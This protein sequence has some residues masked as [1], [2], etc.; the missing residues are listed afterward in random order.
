MRKQ[1]PKKRVIAIRK[2][3]NW[4]RFFV[5]LALFTGIFLLSVDDIKTMKDV[6]LTTHMNNVH[7][8]FNGKKYK[9]DLVRLEVLTDTV[10]KRLEMVYRI[11]GGEKIPS[12]YLKSESESFQRDPAE[13][14]EQERIERERVK[15]Q[16]KFDKGYEEPVKKEEKE[17]TLM[18][19][20]QAIDNPDEFFAEE[21]A[22]RERSEPKI[23]EDLPQDKE[24]NNITSIQDSLNR[25]LEAIDSLAP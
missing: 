14:T 16:A 1:L 24:T 19:Q 18:E 22:E 17:E 2:R 8:Y 12:D 15:E 11:L 23:E 10:L 21:K 20:V 9:K 6:P 4:R 25:G 3:T 13:Q 5:L 7:Q